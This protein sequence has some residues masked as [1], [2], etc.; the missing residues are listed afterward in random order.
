VPLSKLAKSVY[1][2]RFLLD[3]KRNERA[4]TYLPVQDIPELQE[5]GLYFAVMKRP[6]QFQDQFETAFFTV[7]DIGLH[8]RAY[9]DK[10]YVH[11]ASLRNGGAI[12]G[13]ELRILDPR[14]D[15]FLK[16]ATD[17]NGNVLLN[18]KLQSGHVLVARL[19]SDV[20]L[21]PFNQPALDLSEFAVAGRESA[22][23]D[24]F[25]WSGRD[26]YRPG[27]TVRVSARFRD[28]DCKPVAAKGKGGAQPLF[29]RPKQPDG[30][31]ARSGL[32]RTDH[33]AYHDMIAADLKPGE[34]MPWAEAR[35]K[36]GSEEFATNQ[37]TGRCMPEIGPRSVFQSTAAITASTRLLIGPAAAIIM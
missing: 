10:L 26:L 32:W 15:T 21:L 7:S 18:Y 27:E 5:P 13:V 19:G 2:N 35:F 11:A 6:G 1:V 9:K 28:H 33:G 29:V 14:G 25:A 4:L 24:V 23:F 22:W 17:G 36:G 34:T 3:V 8:A 37:P 12:G 30:K 20:S 16:G 31:T